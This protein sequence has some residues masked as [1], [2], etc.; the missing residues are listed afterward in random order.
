MIH[1][2]IFSP[3]TSKDK[4]RVEEAEER[5]KTLQ[6]FVDAQAKELDWYREYTAK[7]EGR[8]LE[9]HKLLAASV[10]SELS[11]KQSIRELLAYE[12]CDNSGT[13]P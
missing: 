7:L 4:R 6:G 10:E 5:I 1:Q 2:K 8:I 12:E 11:L 3:E 9:L 13:Y